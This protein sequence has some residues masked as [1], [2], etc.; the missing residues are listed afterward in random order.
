MLCPIFD[1]GFTALLDDLADRGLL[2]E[3]LVVAI[4]E[5]GRTPR[6]NGHGGR[7]HWGHVF[8]F[9]LAG[10]GISGGQVI[11]LERPPR[12]LPRDGRLEPQD[13]TATIFHLLGIPHTAAFTD[14]T[15]RPYPVSKG[16][17][18]YT[19]LGEGTGDVR[20][21]LSRPGTCHSYPNTR[22]IRC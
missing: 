20:N 5:F 13:L 8:S 21:A 4:G 18:I 10:A 3:T 15:G 22:V 2:A 14:M 6:I 16:E 7:D 9:A 1:I 12:C 11:R 19:L 17:P